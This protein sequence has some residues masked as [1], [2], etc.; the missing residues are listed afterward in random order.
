MS[1]ILHAAAALLIVAIGDIAVSA[2]D[3]VAIY[4]RIDRVVLAPSAEAPDTI[5]VF[6]V[7][8]V[9]VPRDMNDYQ[10]VKRG[11]LYYKLPAERQ[12]ARREWNDLK[13]VA[14]TNQIVAFGL[15]WEGTPTVRPE[16][17]RPTNADTYTLNTGV[18]K[19]AGRNDYAPIRAIVEFKP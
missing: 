4:A 7:F 15:R 6:G 12:T 2:S 3:R 11:Y 5:Q 17:E 9:A 18:V 19:I 10:P 1:R 16:A 14:G 13:Q 8:S